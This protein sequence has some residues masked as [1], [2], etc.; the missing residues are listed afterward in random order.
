M[1]V[2]YVLQM[3]VALNQDAAQDSRKPQWRVPIPE[4][5]QMD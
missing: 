1:L 5:E 2:G 3:S 4:L